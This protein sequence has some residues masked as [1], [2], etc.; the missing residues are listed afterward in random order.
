MLNAC[1]PTMKIFFVD[2]YAQLIYNA[3]IIVKQ[4]EKYEMVR[5]LSDQLM[6]NESSEK[7]EKK[8]IKQEV[9]KPNYFEKLPDVILKHN[10]FEL[11]EPRT[12]DAEFTKTS[13]RHHQLF[14]SQIDL[15]RFMHHVAHG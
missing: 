7:D 2:F 13:K 3:Q 12:T 14:Q 10:L 11:T 1:N 5:R 6:H 4:F 8:E 15:P 9:I